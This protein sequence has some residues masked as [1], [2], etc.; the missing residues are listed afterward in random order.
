MFNKL[1]SNLPFNPSLID[2]VTFYSKRLR[3]ESGLRRL[4]FLFVALAFAFQ[5]FATVSPTEASNQCSSNDVIRCGFD[6]RAEAVQ[7]CRENSYGFGSIV[8]YY[9][10][11]C[12]NL[13]NAATETISTTA[14]N[15]SLFSMGRVKYG[16]RG[17]YGVDIPG[18]GRLYLRNMSS[19]GTYNTKVLSMKTPD[20]QPFMVMYDCGN[21]VI[22]GGYTPPSKPAPPSNLKLA[23]VNTPV[24][25]VKPGETIDYV[26]A[27]SN[28]GGD[29]AFFS[30]N[31]QLPDQ[32][33]Y[34][35]SE[36]HTWA[37]ERN[38]NNLKWHNNTPP[39][40]TFGNTD[41][42]GSPG[43]IKV[44]VKVKQGVKSGT[45]LCN[46][47][48]LIDVN[49]STKKAQTWSEVSVCNTVVIECPAG[50]IPTNNGDCV[51]PTI[52]DAACS[53]IKATPISKTKYKFDTVS[54]TVNGATI[55]NY[56][57][58][59]GDNQTKTNN[60]SGL[61]DSVEHEYSKPGTYK[62]TVVV[63]TSVADKSS[64]LCQ[65][66]ITIPKEN[67]AM[68][69][70]SKKAA[71]ITKNLSDANGT[72][73]NA[74]DVIEYSLTNKNFGD[75]EAK[76]FILQPED[77]SDV[78]EYADI[79]LTSLGDAVFEQANNKI[80]WNKPV[81]IKPGESI[82][83]KFKVK[84]KSP[85][86]STLRPNNAPGN[87]FDMVMYN[88][89]G[90]D[91]EIK[92]PPTLLKTTETTTTKLPSTGPG[93]SLAISGIITTVVGYFFARSRLL[94]KELELVTE[95]YTTTSGGL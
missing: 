47:A 25:N 63:G 41:I 92:L 79:D 90:N 15:D 77:L 3:K 9:G 26:L 49:I 19:W 52:P 73:A 89:Y 27:F 50:T 28:T 4:G 34:V 40:Y 76:D 7:R 86:P 1:L 70:P 64:L 30:V 95:E 22:K 18:A 54:T 16:K 45:V 58:N 61:K 93:E 23:K 51:T 29:A 8:Q 31:D 75:A 35:S 56:T 57:Y 20:G 13:A 69:V 66:Q 88:K 46:K 17:E 43:F 48:W 21:I 2:Q 67:I 14:Q 78:L 55:K 32:V 42:L 44:K 84:V 81:S 72:T 5:I 80:A 91:V 65:T 87:S 59:F 33:E 85:I 62:I 11:S 36:Q 94:T 37:L 53:T 24:G 12:D 74:G 10:M 6:T 38:G 39:F 82:T 60:N 68:V 71:N 83:K